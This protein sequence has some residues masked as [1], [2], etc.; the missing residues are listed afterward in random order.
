M[1]TT[2]LS[3]GKYR[4]DFREKSGTYDIV[5]GDFLLASCSPAL[6]LDGRKADFGSWSVTDATDRTLSASAQS[7]SGVWNIS[8]DLAGDGIKIRLGGTP[9]ARCNAISFWYF[10]AVSLEA[11]HVFTPW[12]RMFRTVMLPLE[13]GTDYDFEGSMQCFISRKDQ[14]LQLSF[15]L[16]GEHIPLFRGHGAEGCLSNLKAGAEIKHFSGPQLV[17]PELTLRSGNGFELAAK[18]ADENAPQKKDFSVSSA[19][20]WNSWDYYRWT[21]TEEAVLEN[22][23]FIAGDPVLSKHVKKI[24]IDDGW[25]YAYGEWEANSLFP[26]GMKYMA[27]K[28]SALGFEPGLWVAPLIVEPHARIAQLESD[29]LARSEGGLPTLCWECMQRHAFILDPTVE[30]SR[31]FIYDIFKKRTDDGFRHFKLDFLGAVLNARQ[32]ADKTAGRGRLMELA[33]S[34]IREA[35][36]GK[37]SLLGCN[38]LYSGGGELVESA[39]I[40]GD[41]RSSWHFI[42]ANAPS[43][44]GMFWAN[45]KL[46]LNDPDFALC[47]SLDTSDDPDM[48]KLKFAI[49]Y[50]TPEDTDPQNPCWTRPL[51]EAGRPQIEVLLSLMLAVN[52]AINFS[53]RMSR[54]NKEGLELARKVVTAPPAETALPLDVFSKALP[55]RWLQKTC[56]GKWRVLLI[57]WED[58]TQEMQFDLRAYGINSDRAVNFWN[59]EP[60]AVRDGKIRVGLASHTGLYAVIG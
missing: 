21:V 25:Q 28:I 23:E 39:R 51:V 15:P 54:L 8:F 11:E 18:Y 26:H 24:I 35:V 10:D 29:M 36:A 55:G 47:R 38:Y 22:A 31:R 37:A 14:Q 13:A 4:V 52:G 7:S 57:N 9:A 19:P 58:D 42:Q 16:K 34:P 2:Q 32:F 27:E 59:G 41:I 46:W 50:I 3:F 43:M 1:N 49:V 53:D 5:C 60:V 17:L 44:A 40:G 12:I 33:V 6:Y 20:G 56:D 30:K 48:N 45:R